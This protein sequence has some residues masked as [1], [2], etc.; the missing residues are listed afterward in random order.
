MPSTCPIC[1]EHFLSWTEYHTHT[2][3]AHN[4]KPTRAELE[5]NTPKPVVKGAYG[6]PMSKEEKARIVA[7]GEK[8][9]G[10]QHFYG[11]L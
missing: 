7:A 8:R 6:G 1:L 5:R 11:G 10:K 4:V 9:L 3:L 2:S